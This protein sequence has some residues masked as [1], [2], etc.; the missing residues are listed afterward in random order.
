MLIALLGPG[1]HRPPPPVQTDH[2]RDTVVPPGGAPER[3]AC[4][5]EP[6]GHDAT[7]PDAGRP[8]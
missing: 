3:A 1:L 8:R 7:D 4:L 5:A 2:A 6:D